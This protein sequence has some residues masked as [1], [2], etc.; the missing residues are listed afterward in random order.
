MAGRLRPL[1]IQRAKWKRERLLITMTLAPRLLTA[2][3]EP[4]TP[5]RP[6]P[7]PAHA[8]VP[9]SRRQCAIDRIEKNLE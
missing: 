5:P 4:V 1:E 3:P 9:V 7:M 2:D 6:S 8:I